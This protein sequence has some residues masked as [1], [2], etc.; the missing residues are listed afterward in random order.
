MTTPCSFGLGMRAAVDEEVKTKRLIDSCFEA[1]LSAFKVPFITRGITE[2][3]SGLILR[4][5][6][7]VDHLVPITVDT[8][9]SD[10]IPHVRDP[11]RLS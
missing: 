11:R 7:C 6:A 5:D 4:S 9:V 2:F 3:G 8:A 10:Y 1:A